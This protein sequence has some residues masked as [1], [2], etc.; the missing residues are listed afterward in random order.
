MKNPQQK[1]QKPRV[2]KKETGLHL[3]WPDMM[4]SR[5]KRAGSCTQSRDLQGKPVLG[6]GGV[7]K[8]WGPAA[9][10]RGLVS[11]PQG[12]LATNLLP[13]LRYVLE[14]TC[15]GPSVVLDI[16]T[17][18]IR[19]ARHSLESA[20]RVRDRRQGLGKEPR[21]AW[22]CPSVT[23]ISF[24]PGPHRCWSA[25]GWWRLWCG[26]SCPPAGPPWGR[27]LPPVYTECP[28]LLP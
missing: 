28:V 20:T 13:R 16:L 7:I 24:P 23:H 9:F 8:A 14:V 22:P 21:W 2:L 4:S 17:V 18:L 10:G 25:L 26:N 12:L 11:E 15:P 19:L 1:R 5:Y 27:G 3:S 6:G